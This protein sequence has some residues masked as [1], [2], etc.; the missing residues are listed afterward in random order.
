MADDDAG[1][2]M[3]KHIE[4]YLRTNG[5]E[6]HLW[7]LSGHGFETLTPTLLLRTIGRKSGEPRIVPLIYLP[8]GDEYVIIGS[9]GGA[10]EHPVWFLNIKADPSI[11]FQIGGK[12]WEGAARIAEGEERQRVWD[13]TVGRHP[14]Y[15]KYAENSG[16]RIIPVILLKPGKEIATLEN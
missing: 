14:A 9:K 8:W 13:Y 5:R 16:D 3:A 10:P 4:S 11:A 12:R 15:A 1:D 6:G 2:W 7:D